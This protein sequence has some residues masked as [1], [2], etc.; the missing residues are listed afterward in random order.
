MLFI[1]SFS[2]FTFGATSKMK[3]T[4]LLLATILFVPILA[5]ANSVTGTAYLDANGDGVLSTGESAIAGI[6]VRLLDENDN[7]IATTTS[8]TDGAYSF[9]GIGAG[10]YKIQIVLASGK[11]VTGAPFTKTGEDL[12]VALPLKTQQLFPKIPLVTST[13]G[14]NNVPQQNSNP[15]NPRGEEVSTFVP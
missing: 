6:T 11:K 14:S 12:V 15:A 3:L 5:T 8:G 1:N 4:T 9:A 7:V 10:T 2:F 13:N